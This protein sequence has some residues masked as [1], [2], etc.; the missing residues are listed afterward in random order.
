MPQHT[1]SVS[2]LRIL[3]PTETQTSKAEHP[4]CSPAS[5]RW[6]SH[7]ACLKTMQE[8][9]PSAEERYISSALFVDSELSPGG[10]RPLVFNHAASCSPLLARKRT[11]A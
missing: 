4:Q 8:E 2:R 3:A 5:G 10:S 9:A 7:Q 6:L 1:A 11:P